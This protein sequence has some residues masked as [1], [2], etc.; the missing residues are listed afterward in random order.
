MPAPDL[1]SITARLRAA[2][3][4]FAE[5][6]EALLLSVEQSPAAL[7]AM[8]GRRVAGLPLEQ[9][10]GW[11]E[12][13]GRRILVDPG[14]FVPRR[15]TELLVR[16]A[17]AFCAPGSVMVDLCCG[18]GA[19]A[20]VL[21]VARPGA[22]LFAVDIDPL[23][24]ACAR[25]N[26]ADPGQVFEGDLFAP[27]PVSLTGRVDVIAAN[28]PYVPTNEIALMPVEAR[29][30]EPR[31]TADGGDD[32]LDIQRRIAAAASPWLSPNG[33]LLVETG[34]RQATQT[35]AIFALNGLFPRIVQ[36]EELDS[37]VVIGLL[38]P[39]TDNLNDRLS[40]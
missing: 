10:L 30:Y 36:S 12:F 34:Q 5:E 33:C 20:A 6:E 26:L 28:A 18:S 13:C 40:L 25:R 17:L 29:L 32:G 9:I 21:A 15:R 1:V 38:E 14:V 7:N 31:A 2:G 35:A 11:A 37:T 8:I 39:Q 3:C 27:L 19:V 22:S 23:A 24:V 16:Q 4:V